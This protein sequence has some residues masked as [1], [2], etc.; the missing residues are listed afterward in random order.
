MRQLSLCLFC[1]FLFG[2]SSNTSLKQSPQNAQPGRQWLPNGHYLSSAGKSIPLG[3]FP[4]GMSL[5]PD[6]RSLIVV[7]S[8]YY[9]Q[10]LSVVSVV[11]QSV[12]QTLAIRKSWMGAAWGPY[13]DYF[14]VTAGNDNKVYR[15]G[16]Q[17]DSA[18]FLNSIK[19]AE[20]APAAFVSPT[21]LAIN[22]EG[23]KIYTVS[24]MSPALY[25]LDAYSNTIEKKLEFP[26]PLYTC[27]LDEQRS[28]VYVSEWGADKISVVRSEDLVKIMEIPVGNHPSAMVMNGS[29]SY[30]FVT[31]SGEN[32]VSVINLKTFNIEETIDV[33]LMRNSPA[34]STPNALALGKGDTTLY[35]ALADNNAIAVADIK[36]IGRSSVKGFIP[37]GWYPTA[38]ICADSLLIVANGRGDSSGKNFN[39]ENPFS[40]LKG[41]LSFI[42]VPFEHELKQYTAS[43]L[44]NNPYTREEHYAEWND[45]NPIPQTAGR[46]SPIKHVFYIVKELRSY[47][48]LFGDMPA[49]NGDSSFVKYGSSVTPNHHALSQEFVLFDNFYSNGQNSINGM[50]W[51]TAAYSND[52]TEKTVPTLYGRRGGAF[53]YEQVGI[54]TPKSGYIW[55]A[56]QKKNLSVRNYGM[57]LNEEASQRGEI[58]PLAAGLLKATSPYYRGWDLNYYDTSRVSGWMK[59]FDAFEKGDSLPQFS[60]I[61]LPNDHTG[62]KLSKIKSQNAFVAD[63]DLAL[64]KIVERISRS[65]YWKTSAIFVLE[66]SANGGSDHVDAH[67]SAALAISPYIKRGSVDHTHYT[68]TSV[69]RTMELILG[70]PPMTQHDAGAV[71]MFRAFQAMP[72]TTPYTAKKN[73][74]PLNELIIVTPTQQP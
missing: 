52:Y 73:I 42:P 61:R 40:H 43:V 20:E 35:V 10:T 72:D 59:E 41:S 8:G 29:G 46:Q 18:W 27:L 4:L 47:D 64:G 66:S 19:L 32:T 16:F 39:K 5:S 57:F 50:Q 58:I 69:L 14:F 28:C 11:S 25:K 22:S 12:K 2:C 23:D 34:G 48:E 21:G 30:L 44:A 74:V 62:G 9:Q 31:N 70:V 33:A 53:D 24:K 13:G 54:A 26:A 65:K 55:D 7:N 3:D 49:G 17:N 51:S 67:R 15:Y 71:P 38:V 37:T 63:N 56:A 6:K 68:T 1:V 45:V 60:V 36:T